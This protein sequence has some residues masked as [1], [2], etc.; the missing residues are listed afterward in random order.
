MKWSEVGAMDW[1][2]KQNEDVITKS[3][4]AKVTFLHQI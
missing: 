4:Q 3:I 2:E 1:G